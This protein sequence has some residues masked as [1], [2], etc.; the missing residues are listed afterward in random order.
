MLDRN[1]EEAIF[2]MQKL[3]TE[4]GVKQLVEEAAQLFANGRHMEA[5]AL[6][7]KAEAIMAN[8]GASACGNRPSS[9]PVGRNEHKQIGGTRESGRAGEG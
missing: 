5:G 9:P 8:R 4:N 6:L 2:Q 1:L 3:N 7:E